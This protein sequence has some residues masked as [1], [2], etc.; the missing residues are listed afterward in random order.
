MSR[1]TPEGVETGGEAAPSPRPRGE[2][3]WLLFRERTALHLLSLQGQLVRGKVHLE[4]R[5]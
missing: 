1:V 5:E 4:P 3:A 2:S